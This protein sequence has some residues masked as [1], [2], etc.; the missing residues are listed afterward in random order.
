MADP[1]FTKAPTHC[2]TIW[3][4]WQTVDG[5]AGQCRGVHHDYS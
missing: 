1:W 3:G 2:Q 4:L 5:Q